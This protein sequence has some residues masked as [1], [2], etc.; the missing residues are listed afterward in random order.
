MCI[1]C[2][3]YIK[4]SFLMIEQLSKHSEYVINI[5]C[6][7]SFTYQYSIWKLSFW[8]K[9]FIVFISKLWDVS[10][11][12]YFWNFKGFTP[13]QPFCNSIFGIPMF[14]DSWKFTSNL[15][16]VLILL[17]HEVF[18]VGMGNLFFLYSSACSCVKTVGENSLSWV[19]SIKEI[20]N[21]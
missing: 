9:L 21:A 14:D 8:A 16:T 4:N 6:S 1:L 12:F 3:K 2:Q 7:Q 20:T 13:L 10:M 19:T 15:F 5:C 17:L 11:K 18:H